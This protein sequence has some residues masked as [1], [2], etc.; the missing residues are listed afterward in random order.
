MATM[1]R[2]GAF[3]DALQPERKRQL[4]SLVHDGQK[5]Q[6]E[7]EVLERAKSTDEKKYAN[8]VTPAAACAP[9]FLASQTASLPTRVTKSVRSVAGAAF[10]LTA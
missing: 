1:W 5:L 3:G 6:K 4:D 2:L 8:E 9:P 7:I 10:H